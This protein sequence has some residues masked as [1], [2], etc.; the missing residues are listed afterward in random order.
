M[1]F[2]LNSWQVLLPA[3]ICL[4]GRITLIGHET[5]NTE[6]VYKGDK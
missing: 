4:V 1:F 2:K 6:D 5:K 3:V